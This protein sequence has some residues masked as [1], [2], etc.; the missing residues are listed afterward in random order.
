MYFRFRS[1]STHFFDRGILPSNITTSKH[2]VL[3]CKGCPRHLWPCQGHQK[4]L[5]R[6]GKFEI[7][8]GAKLSTFKDYKKIL[9]Q[10]RTKPKDFF[11]LQQHFGAMFV[12]TRCAT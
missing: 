6:T 10:S 9:F 1:T 8:Q 3:L 2:T 7:L 4:L 12:L 5:V 11:N